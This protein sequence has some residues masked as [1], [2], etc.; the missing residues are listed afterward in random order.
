MSV[1]FR[2]SDVYKNARILVKD[3]SR[4]IYQKKK[5]R[6]APGEMECITLKAEL[7]ENASALQF[8]LEVAE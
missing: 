6:L 1:Y 2:V 7:F 5:A 3:Q 8:E 4:V